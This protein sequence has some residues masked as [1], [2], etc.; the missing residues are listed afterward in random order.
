M[1]ACTTIRPRSP[2]SAPGPML[3]P[4]CRPSIMQAVSM[5]HP[6]KPA[7][8]QRRLLALRVQQHAAQ[9]LAGGAN[10]AAPA[11]ARHRLGPVTAAT[12]QE[13]KQ[14]PPQASQSEPKSSSRHEGPRQ[15][16]TP[17][18]C[19]PPGL[20]SSISNVKGRSPLH[21]AASSSS[22]LPF[23]SASCRRSPVTRSSSSPRSDFSLR[24]LLRVGQA[25]RVRQAEPVL[26]HIRDTRSSA[27]RSRC[28]RAAR[29][30]LWHALLALLPLVCTTRCRVS[31][32]AGPAVQCVRTT[33]P[34]APPHPAAAH[35]I[36]A[37][38]LLS[39]SCRPC[40]SEL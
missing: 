19:T 14:E 4:R 15:T 39:W 35:V 7:R 20:G 30:P 8:L 24:S 40:S 36:S 32:H 22:S 31:I 16:T 17:A 37:V 13:H 12:Q 11:R 2:A 23:S 29:L 38:A 25:G 10:L 1:G 6:M 5:K 26:A 34:R 18:R 21:L 33:R 9:V 27:A 28:L 3:L